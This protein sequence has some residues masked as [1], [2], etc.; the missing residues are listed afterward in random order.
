[1]RASDERANVLRPWLC[2]EGKPVHKRNLE[3]IRHLPSCGDIG[4]G[5]AFIERRDVAAEAAS[6]EIDARRDTTDLVALA[7]QP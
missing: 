3:S 4:T 7:I 5:L 1:M 6:D 2:A